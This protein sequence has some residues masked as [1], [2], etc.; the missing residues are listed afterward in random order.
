MTERIITDAI[1]REMRFISIL[2]SMMTL[3]VS[4]CV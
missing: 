2:L 1:K 4:A 3:L